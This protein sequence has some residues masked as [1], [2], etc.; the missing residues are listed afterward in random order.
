MG[1]PVAG[2]GQFAGFCVTLEYNDLIGQ[3]IGYEQKVAVRGE[4]EI[5]EF[6][7]DP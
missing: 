3:L 6:A 1:D 4:V 7:P 2:I 5:V